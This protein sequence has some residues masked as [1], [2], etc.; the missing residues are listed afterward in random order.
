[1]VFVFHGDVRTAAAWK[2]LLEFSLRLFFLGPLIEYV[3]TC[4]LCF[5]SEVFLAG[6]LAYLGAK[7]PGQDPEAEA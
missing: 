6:L 3:S 7:Q 2:L 5:V 1:M 4:T